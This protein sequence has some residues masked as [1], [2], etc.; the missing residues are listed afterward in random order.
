M[1]LV[2]DFHPGSDD[3][4]DGAGQPL[5]ENCGGCRDHRKTR[6]EASGQRAQHRRRRFL[7]LQLPPGNY[8]VSAEMSGSNRSRRVMSFVLPTASKV[9][10]G[11]L[12]REVGSISER[13]RSTPGRAATNSVRVGQAKS[14]S[15]TNRQL[16][17]IGLNGGHFPR[18][19]APKAACK[20]VHISHPRTE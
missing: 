13:S 11:K 3:V 17:N 12:V 15:A 2:S 1:E 20:S 10:V 7:F 9:N 18:R 19:G 16:R 5:G 8:T 4:R 14:Q 6:L